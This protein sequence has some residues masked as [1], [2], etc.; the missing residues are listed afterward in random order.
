MH[1]FTSCV[2]CALRIWCCLCFHFEE[3]WA[4]TLSWCVLVFCYPGQENADLGLFPARKVIRTSR[5]FQ[6]KAGNRALLAK[7][8]RQGCAGALLSRL[9]TCWSGCVSLQK[10]DLNLWF[11]PGKSQLLGSACPRFR[12]MVPRFAYSGA[13]CLKNVSLVWKQVVNWSNFPFISNQL[14]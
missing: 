4:A 9:G 14:F 2:C 1:S 8:L 5:K 6:E 10:G 7:G 3:L 13:V 12:T 11:S